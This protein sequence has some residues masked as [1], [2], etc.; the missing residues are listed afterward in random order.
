MQEVYRTQRIYIPWNQEISL[1]CQQ[2]KKIYNF[3]NYIKRQDYFKKHILFKTFQFTLDQI[4]DFLIKYPYLKEKD[5]RL[6]IKNNADFYVNKKYKLVT[7]TNVDLILQQLHN[8]WLSF[9]KA[10]NSYFKNKTKFK[11]IP[12]PPKYIKKDEMNLLFRD[13]KHEGKLIDTIYYPPTFYHFTIKTNLLNGTEINTLKIIPKHKKYLC[14]FSYKTLIPDLKEFNNRIAGIDLGKRNFVTLTFNQDNLKPIIIK[15]G[16]IVSINKF[17][18]KQK[19]ILSSNY[20][21]LENHIQ[22]EINHTKLEILSEKRQRRIQGYFEYI[23]SFIV[24]ILQEYT[25]HTLVIGYNEEWKQQVKLGRKNNRKF[26]EI[27][28]LQFIN[29]LKTKC[30]NFGIDFYQINEAYTSKCSFVDNESIKKHVS[31]MGQRNKGLFITAKGLKMNSDINGSLNIIR[32]LFP[33][34]FTQF[35]IGQGIKAFS[36]ALIIKHIQDVNVIL[37]QITS[38]TLDKLSF[39]DPLH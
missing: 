31:Y 7:G 34:A 6:F 15:G 19:D 35:D 22:S 28:Y 2:S 14:F 24:T 36:Q 16:Y 10:R 13:L 18:N 11:A 1:A 23:A 8:E 38:K 39:I 26:V 17:W 32:K 30:F 12:K 4:K 5:L 33:D 25:V 27:P 3:A 29:I 20:K 9:F 21:L 37:S